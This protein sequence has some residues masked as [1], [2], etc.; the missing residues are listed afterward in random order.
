MDSILCGGVLGLHVS[1]QVKALCQHEG[2]SQPEE[3]KQFEIDP[4]LF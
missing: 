2:E 4:G 1:G 3:S